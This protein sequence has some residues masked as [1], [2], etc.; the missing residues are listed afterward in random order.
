I[1]LQHDIRTLIGWHQ[2]REDVLT[3]KA[4]HGRWRVLSNTTEAE[5]P[6]TSQRIWLQESTSGKYA[7]ILNFAHNANLQTLDRHWLVGSEVDATI[8]YY[9]GAVP[10]RAIADKI[11]QPTALRVFQEGV[12]IADALHSVQQALAMNP[13]LTRYPLVLGD[14][15]VGQAAASAQSTR[16]S[17]LYDRECHL[18]PIHAKAKAV[19]KLLSITGGE[20][21]QVFGE[22]LGDGFLPLGLWHN[23]RYWAL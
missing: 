17:Y 12:A 3:G 6:L 19:W 4:L 16:Q 11:A 2:N 8:Y 14:V 10:L 18:L 7:L 20:P 1:P 21:A 23:E 22:W 15:V 9:A 5:D 13:W